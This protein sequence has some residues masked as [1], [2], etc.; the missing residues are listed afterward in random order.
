MAI[1]AVEIVQTNIV[2]DCDLLAIHSPLIFLANATYNTAPP[3]NLYLFIYDKDDVLLG[4]YKSLPNRD[5]SPTVRQF[6]FRAD[7]VLRQ[8]LR[9][10]EDFTQADNTLVEVPDMTKQFKIKFSNLPKNTSGY[11]I[12]TGTIEGLVPGGYPYVISSRAKI[13]GVERLVQWQI[14]S[15]DEIATDEIV[16]ARTIAEWEAKFPGIIGTK[17]QIGINSGVMY[18]RNNTSYR[19]EDLS[20]PPMIQST[21][22]CTEYPETEISAYVDFYATTA[23]SQ[24][25]ET[26]AK[27]S[28]FNNES[29]CITGIK[30]KWAYA[31]FYDSVG[32]GTITASTVVEGTNPCDI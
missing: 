32:I 1:T 9:P 14:F 8:W 16:L 23:A 12:K 19:C 15:A 2:G 29:Q 5:I 21:V 18:G 24:F 22:V 27:Q 10:I 17:L 26:E 31:Y 11:C 25:G 4:S 3:D 30:G 6:R 7:Q 20:C 28:L 13:D